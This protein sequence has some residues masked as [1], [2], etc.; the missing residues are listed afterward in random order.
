[1][2]KSGI[3]VGVDAVRLRAG[4][5]RRAFV[6]LI[7]RIGHDDRRARTAA[8]DHRLREREQRFAAAEYRQH[9]RAGIER[10]QARGDA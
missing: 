4:Q 7:E 8:V 6:D 10:A 5:E 3:R 1:M 2:R 9:F